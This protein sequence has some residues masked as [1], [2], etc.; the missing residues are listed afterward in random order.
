MLLCKCPAEKQT[1]EFVLLR[2]KRPSL[3][4]TFVEETSVLCLFVDDVDS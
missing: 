1:R 2:T 4:Q 3:K